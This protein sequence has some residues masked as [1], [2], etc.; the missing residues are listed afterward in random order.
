MLYFLW[1]MV[2]KDIPTFWGILTKWQI[3]IVSAGRP[4]IGIESWSAFNIIE[5]T[6]HL[7]LNSF[8]LFP[9]AFHYM[10]LMQGV[11]YQSTF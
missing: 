4:F 5:F 3:S 8:Y 6:A 7:N 9:K 2:D 11:F 1:A 10:Q